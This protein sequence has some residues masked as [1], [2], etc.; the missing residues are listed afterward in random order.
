MERQEIQKII[1]KSI[2]DYDMKRNENKYTDFDDI[3][4]YIEVINVISP[5]I[6]TAAGNY[7]TYFLAPRTLSIFQIDFSATTALATSDTNY[8][9]WT[10]TNLGQD[11]TGTKSMLATTP[12]GTSTTKATGG[13]A[14]AAN[15]KMTFV[16]T[17]TLNNL[18]IISGDRILIRAAV[19]GTLANTVT[20]PVYLIQLS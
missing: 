10:I 5:T 1:S 14:I 18:Q 12:A 7:D 6:G 16:T 13:T 20:F 8:I 17:T 11:G 3:L 15:T 19:T 4:D 9:T 2:Q